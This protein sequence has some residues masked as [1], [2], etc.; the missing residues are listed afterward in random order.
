MNQFQPLAADDPRRLGAY[1]IVA[2]LGEGGQGVVY[3]GKSDT[4]EQV[5]VKLLHHALVAD[6]DAR[7]RFLREVAVAQRV[8]RFCTAPVL[9][10][11]LDGSRPYIV[12]EYVPGP[13]LR[14]L[15]LTEGPRRGAA[16]ERLAIS[17]ATALAAIHRA[18]ILHRD[19]KPANVLMGPEGPVVIDFG[20]ARAL[21]S[22]GATATG[23]AMGTPSYLAPEQ[24]SGAAV[25]EAAD[26]FAW[27]VTMVFAATGK[28]AFGA[29][30][31]PVVMNRILNEEPELG[32]MEGELGELVAACLSKDPAQRP[33][34]DGL[35]LRLTGQPAPKAAIEPVTGQH[36]TGAPGPAQPGHPGQGGSGPQPM[37]PPHQGPF[38]HLAAAIQNGPGQPPIPGPA[39]GPGGPQAGGPGAPGGPQA[40]APGVPPQAGMPG[41]AGPGVPPQ[42][43]VPGQAGAAGAP[44]Q[45]GMPGQ[46]GPGVPPQA[47]GP[48]QAGPGVPPQAGGP[49]QGGRG[50]YG[51]PRSQP[52]AGDGAPSKQRRTMTLALSG[53]AAAALLVV[54]GAVVVQANS[55]QVPVVAVGDA[56]QSTEDG[57]SAAGKPGEPP[58]T[59]P[60]ADQVL[61]TDSP[62]PVGT[63]DIEEPEKTGKKKHS[64]Q[65][66]AQIPT[67]PAT[68]QPR[69]Q[70]QTTTERPQATSTP[71]PTR[72]KKKESLG[73]DP[74]AE[75]T[76]APTHNPDETTKT[77]APSKAPAKRNPYTAAGVCGA[78][79][80]VI[81]SHALGSY[82]T[83]YLLWNASAGK[84][85]VVTL[86]RYVYPNKVEMNAILQVKGGSSASNPGSFS[87]YAGPVRLPAAKKCVIWGG[88][89]SNVSWKSGW[90]HCS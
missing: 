6:A 78:G 69:P 83:V 56:S 50:P 80:K 28:P 39:T 48:G 67:P 22:P 42:G 2:R 1:D 82:A 53:A 47:G 30:S 49:G 73:V 19:F 54:A 16:L 17:T 5:A 84:N 24:L 74:E 57:G 70:T 8:A 29:D 20:I 63:L 66:V 36:L 68:A 10:A 34:A 18:G 58:S 21:D 79:Y 33:T 7:T 4:G 72:T 61:P 13:S 51:A 43:G 59:Q 27:G 11:D 45:A 75:P 90:T 60:T 25:S 89:I 41:Q 55:K 9:H 85:C 71:K 12:S 37:F 76:D 3:L 86:S 62:V 81:N 14:E 65:P 52:P 31:I 88:S 77:H 87:T 46:A 23:M 40:G 38:P 15:V 35:I 64:E 32:G 26:V 44:S